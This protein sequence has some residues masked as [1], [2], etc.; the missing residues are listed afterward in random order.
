M[1]PSF[2]RTLNLPPNGFWKEVGVKGHTCSN[3]HGMALWGWI[4]HSTYKLTRVL[5]KALAYIVHKGRGLLF[6]YF[7]D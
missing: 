4:L 2:M 6:Y 3:M 1:F 7:N 5:F